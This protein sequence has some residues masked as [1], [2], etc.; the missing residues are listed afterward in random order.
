MRSTFAFSKLKQLIA[1][2]PDPILLAF[3]CD[4]TEG[5]L[6]LYDQLNPADKTPLQAVALLQA[7]GLQ[8]EGLSELADQLMAYEIIEG[9]HTLRLADDKNPAYQLVY[10]AAIKSPKGAAFG[11]ALATYAFKRLHAWRT[12]DGEAYATLPEREPSAQW[13][14]MEHLLTKPDT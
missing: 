11:V 1:T 9:E 8:A 6:P 13:R 2:A 7:R 4:L 14:W 3:A 10:H 5:V 12:G